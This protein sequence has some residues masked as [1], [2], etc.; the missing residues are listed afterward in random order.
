MYMRSKWSV[1][2]PRACSYTLG[3]GSSSWSRI[4]W[5]GPP[6]G[7][8]VISRRTPTVRKCQKKSEN[9]GKCQKMSENVGNVSENVEKCQISIRFH[10]LGKWGDL[11]HPSYYPHH[12]S[13]VPVSV[14][15]CVSV[16]AVYLSDVSVYLPVCLPISLHFTWIVLPTQLNRSKY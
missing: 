6:R 16:S 14:S 1:N 11:V 10:F 2:V 5:E 9:V 4:P 13:C 3:R 8:P 7:E 12:N 15:H